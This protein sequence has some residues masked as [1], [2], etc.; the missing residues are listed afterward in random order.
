MSN[1][2][3]KSI[4][5]E[6]QSLADK[7]NSQSRKVGFFFGAGASIPASLPDMFSLTKKVEKE[8]VKTS[9]K[10]IFNK[11][12]AVLGKNQH[13]EHILSFIEEV[14]SLGGFSKVLYPEGF[15]PYKWSELILEIK[16]LISNIIEKDSDLKSAAH[17]CFSRWLR[18]R[19][20]DT[21]IFTTNYDLVLETAF[22]DED[23]FYFDGFI[24]GIS[25]KFQAATVDPVSMQVSEEIRP[26]NS[27]V[28]LWK[29]HGSINWEIKTD[30]GSIEV[31]R[32][33]QRV[34]SCLIYPSSV[35]YSDSRRMPYLVMQDRFRKYLYSSKLTLVIVGYGFG[36]E[37]LNE[38]IYDALRKNK[39]LD[40]NILSFKNLE[41]GNQLEGFINKDHLN[42]TI[43]T[44]NKYIHQGEKYDWQGSG[45]CNLGDSKIFFEQIEMISKL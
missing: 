23:L 8:I 13:I 34:E 26:P 33:P 2:I 21:E 24:G 36:D 38:T 3:E 25:P 29:M 16:K 9:H 1:E 32:N 22:E 19:S 30:C 18:T 11:L 4:E 45:V 31:R 5:K 35:K 20:G 15:E 41:A 17:R 37:H 14:S 6:F 27:W 39:N 28:R 7:L 44:P 40:V 42:L 10:E 12:K 43:F